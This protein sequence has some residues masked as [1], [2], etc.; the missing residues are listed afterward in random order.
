[1]SIAAP[2]AS[3][4]AL[5]E[6]LNAQ[7]ERERIAEE[8]AAASRLKEVREAEAEAARARERERTTEAVAAEMVR[9]KEKVVYSDKIGL[10]I[11]RRIAAGEMLSDICA[12]VSMPVRSSVLE[13]LN[14]ERMSVFQKNYV[15]A[16]D[17]RGELFADQLI[18]IADDSRNDYMD[19]LNTKTGETFRVLDP[20]ALGRSKLRLEMRL[21][22]LKAFNPGRWGDSP[23]TAGALRDLAAKSSPKVIFNFITAAPLPGDAAQIIENTPGVQVNRSQQVTTIGKTKVA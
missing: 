21:R 14:D 4:K 2:S 23:D 17:Y 11:C 16:C 6:Y 9:Y 8:I 15:K 13:W 22:H 5:R 10:Q 3:D 7:K 20:E 19:K 18:T 12:D 1:M